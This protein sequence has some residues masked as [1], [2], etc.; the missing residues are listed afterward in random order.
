MVEI[1][2]DDCF[3][4]PSSSLVQRILFTMEEMEIMEPG[5][6]ISLDYKAL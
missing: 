3:R 4:L 2:L 5:F 1:P 6:W